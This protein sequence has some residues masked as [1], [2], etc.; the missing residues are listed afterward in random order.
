LK[1]MATMQG[2]PAR[3]AAAGRDETTGTDQEVKGSRVSR[4]GP[5]DEPTKTP[6]PADW[7]TKAAHASSCSRAGVQ[8]Q[9][10]RRRGKGG[11]P[12]FGRREE[13]RSARTWKESRDAWPS[14]ETTR[15]WSWATEEAGR[16]RA[17]LRA[18]ENEGKGG[19]GQARGRPGSAERS[20]DAGMLAAESG[21]VAL[22][23]R[24]REHQVSEGSTT[25]EQGRVIE[26]AMCEQRRK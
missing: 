15:D 8:M 5:E 9:D 21:A 18:Q 7:T 12:K 4:Q 3:P 23:L 6:E 25:R 17:R 13:R 26:H 22:A 14:V 1:A 11:K 20:G 2:L 19:G 24:G 10:Q 16:N